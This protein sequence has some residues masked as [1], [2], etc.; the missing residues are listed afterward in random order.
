[1]SASEDEQ[2]ARV[3][4]LLSHVIPPLLFA[5]AVA[6]KNTLKKALNNTILFDL[7]KIHDRKIRTCDE[8]SLSA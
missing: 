6:L 5:F 3:M 2:K 4:L 8:S 7:Q 1:M